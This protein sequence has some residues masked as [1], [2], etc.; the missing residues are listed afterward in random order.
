MQQALWGAGVLTGAA[1]DSGA[2]LRRRILSL[3]PEDEQFD[4]LEIATLVK[5]LDR[6]TVERLV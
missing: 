1:E 3:M 5:R 6:S 4:A 2:P